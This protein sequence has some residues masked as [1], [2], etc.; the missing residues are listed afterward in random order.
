MSSEVKWHALAVNEVL[1]ILKSNPLGLSVEEAEKRLEI[2]GPNELKKEKKRGR[3]KIFIDQFK[4]ILV[5]IL[6]LAAALS[7]AIGEVTD[8]IVILAIVVASAILGFVQEYRAE[9]ALEA[10]K[11]LTAPTATVV[12]N[13]E[14]IEIP[15]REIVPGDILVLNAG[16]KVPADARIIESHNLKVD[17]APLTGESVTIA[18]V[19]E[20]LSEDT[21]LSDR[22]NMV[23]AGTVVTYG[24]G[25][26]IVVATGMNT[27]LGKI[28]ASVQETEK[29][30]TPLERR[31]VEIGRILAIM[32]LSVAGFVAAVGFFIWH[33][34]L[35]EM[36][37]WA[38]SLAVAAVP[39]ALPAVVTG[40]LAVGMYRMAKRKAIVRRLPA[41]ETLGSTTI[42]CSDKTGTM[43]KGEMTVRKIYVNDKLIDVTGSGYE[44]KGEFVLNGEILEN[45]DEELR[46]LL[47][48][49]ALC[50]DAK[51]VRQN[52]RW[53]IRGDPTEGA[54]IVAAVKAGIAEDE[55]KKYPRVNEIPFSSE[56]K[57]M[58]TI[59][60]T[61]DLKVLAFMKG[62]PEVVLNLCDKA[63]INGK[64]MT[65]D[66]N[67]RKKILAINNELASNGLRNLAIA[68]KE[69]SRENVDKLLGEEFERGF[70]FL[71]LVGMMDP[72]RP[73]VKEAIN[74]CKDAGIKTVMITGDHKLTAIAIAKELGMF[75][76]DDLALTGVELEKMSDEEL[77]RIVEK[78]VVYARVSPEHKMKIIRALKK[79]GHIVA[80]T[81]DGVNDA[82][83]LKSADI[84][85]AMGITGTEVAK[86]AADMILADDNFATIVAAVEQGR[87]IYENIKKYLVYLL[88]CNI[89]EIIIPL[90]A[91][92]AALPLPFTAI[93]YLWINLVT[94]GLPALALGIDP[95]DP[96]IMKRP[97]R[98]PKEG[99]FTKKDALLFLVATPL[100]MTLMLL[101]SFYLDLNVLRE[102]LISARTQ[103]FI[104]M[105]MM[106]LTMAL[107][108]R[109]LK[110]PIWRVGVFKN[111]YLILAIASSILMQLMVLYVPALHPAFDVTY[112]SLADWTIALTLSIILLL[113]VEILKMLVK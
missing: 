102:N 74:L 39:E 75:K 108:C 43:T 64:I 83:A 68:Y 72:P 93:Q 73:E 88:R 51:L 49:S 94:D 85:I 41:V 92:L 65:L 57:R 96:D 15:A 70:I 86:E 22:K 34:E 11:K 32:C 67:M 12:R 76:E 33:Y 56:R 99:I 3:I 100:I 98:D 53:I 46:M 31:M 55:L 112:P 16:D 101:G 1:E 77:E 37:M 90:F 111:K 54:L 19:V 81:G 78:V 89:A 7:I 9:K 17:E 109:S 58:T 104:S 44:P 42:I 28:A 52:N 4:N 61:P 103:M 91:S 62:A 80:M 107:S 21:P 23:Y 60:S 30:E 66:E 105:I 38:I 14:E 35:L 24:R 40:A 13:G 71:G 95:A 82:P 110:Y 45:M 97:P 63:R 2:Y 106:E 29:E 48:A 18:K 59:H 5:I 36:T 26:A 10:L 8:S 50:N 69:T 25:K 79:K 6:I 84:G 113:I 87:E 47:L 20:P 27:E